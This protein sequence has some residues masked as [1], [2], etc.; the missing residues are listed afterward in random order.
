MH[1][2]HELRKRGIDWWDPPIKGFDSSISS[3]NPRKF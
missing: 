2:Q 3:M 1:R